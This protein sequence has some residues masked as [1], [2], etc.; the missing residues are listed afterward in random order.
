MYFTV[1][2]KTSTGVLTVKQ[3]IFTLVLL[4]VLVGQA[5]SIPL[6]RAPRYDQSDHSDSSRP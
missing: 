3:I 6:P 4:I 2:S 1:Q 5:S